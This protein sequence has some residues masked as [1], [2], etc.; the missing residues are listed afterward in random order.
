M[1]G[2]RHIRRRDKTNKG[3]G[4]IQGQVGGQDTWGRGKT[5][6]EIY[7]GKGHRGKT[8]G[9]GYLGGKRH[10]KGKGHCTHL[11][12][13]SSRSATVCLR[14]ADEAASVGILY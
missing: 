12:K 13:A 8:Q 7:L 14:F 9:E 2:A 6:G 10:I 11:R 5:Q 1:G 4:K 3:R